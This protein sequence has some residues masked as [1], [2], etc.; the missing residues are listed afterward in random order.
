MI[1]W[2][3]KQT[4]LL[5]GNPKQQIPKA[6]LRIPDDPRDA[7]AIERPSATHATAV[8]GCN[9]KAFA[10]AS[11]GINGGVPRTFLPLLNR[12]KMSARLS[13]PTDSSTG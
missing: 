13:V 4:P 9:P 7:R 2:F 10:L 3:C 6:A 5:D 11:D 8:L 12:Y 1:Y